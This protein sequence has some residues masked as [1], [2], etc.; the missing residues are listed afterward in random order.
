MY[1][2]FSLT[3]HPDQPEMG[4]GSIGAIC[5]HINTMFSAYADLGDQP[6]SQV[7]MY[8]IHI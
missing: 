7:D 4:T 5:A 2:Y 6:A 8:F 3:D 1:I